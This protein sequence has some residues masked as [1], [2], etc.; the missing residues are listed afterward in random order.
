[1]EV[2][3]A[4]GNFDAAIGGAR[5]DEEKARA[6]ERFFSPREAD[7]GW[8]P[9]AQRAELWDIYNSS[10]PP[11]GNMRI[12]PLNNW[13]E[14][15]VWRWLEREKAAIPSLYFSHRRQVVQRPDGTWLPLSEFIHPPTDA[16]IETWDLRFR[17]VGDMTCTSPLKS[18]AQTM[19]EVI[20]EIES[21]S[22]SERGSRAD[23]KVSDAA[24]E[25][26]KREGYF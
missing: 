23:D 22:Q 9:S 1:M 12:F 4:E 17:T 11:N 13:T 16:K 26:R 24:M 25:D 10:L 7:G 15:D 8:D 21:S 20:R 18:T 19:R 14:L 2:E 6:K 3:K 5:R